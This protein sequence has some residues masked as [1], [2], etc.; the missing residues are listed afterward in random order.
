VVGIAAKNARMAWAMLTRGESF[1]FPARGA[2]RIQLTRKKT[3]DRFP[4][5]REAQCVDEQRLDLRGVCLINSR[6]QHGLSAA[7]E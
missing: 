6:W 5:L 3:E 7:N 4:P 2:H 1:R